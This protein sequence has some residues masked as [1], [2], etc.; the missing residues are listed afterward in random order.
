[1]SSQIKYNLLPL[2]QSISYER[3]SVYGYQANHLDSQNVA[4]LARYLWN[5]AL[6]ESFYPSIQLCEITLRNQLYAQVAQKFN[7]LDWLNNSAILVNHRDREDV[8][9]IR[10]SLLKRNRDASAHR[11]IPELSFGFWSGLLHKR[12]EGVLWPWLLKPC[13]PYLAK[14]NR[15]QSYVFQ[16]LNDIRQL[17]NRIFHHEKIGHLTN[18]LDIHQEICDVIAWMA[19]DMLPYLQSIDR[20]DAVYQQ[21][22]GYYEQKLIEKLRGV[23][24]E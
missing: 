15:T 1:M 8:E 5:I 22:A 12:Y 14:R 6:S 20:F 23:T 18:L 10:L 16:R 7:D 19:P 2:V 9:A 13:F 11:I 17:R 24:N 21:G 4:A 3:L